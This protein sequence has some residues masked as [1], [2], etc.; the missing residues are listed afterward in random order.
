MAQTLGS[1]GYYAFMIDN[2]GKVVR[3]KATPE[4]VYD[5]KQQSNGLYSYAEGFS[6]WGY[7]GGDRSVHRLVDSSLA[8]VDSFKAGN[9]YDADSHEFRLLPNGH[10]LLHAYDIQY[11][12]LRATIPGASPN[13][14]VVGSILQELDLNKNVV[15]QWR[16]WDYIP[17]TDTYMSTT[18][19]AF[20]YIHVNAY[21]IDDD[22]NILACFR[23]TCE[24]VKINRMTGAI[25]WR[26]GGKR[27]E[28]TFIGENEANKPTYFT[29]Q[30]T[31]RKLPNGNLILFDNGNLH[32]PAQRYSRAVEY[33]VDQVAKTATL[34][35][36]YRH[37]PDIY[38]PQRGSVQR[39]ANGNTVIGW[40]N[41][42]L[43]GVGKAAFTEV[44]PSKAT[45]CEMEFVNQTSS[46]RALKYEIGAPFSGAATV[47]I[48]EVLRGNTYQ[49]KQGDAQTG[50]S[51]VFSQMAGTYNSVDSE[52]S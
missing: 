32:A 20:D 11:F 35:W 33:K 12:D 38:T 48:N 18:A 44:T 6:A 37:T 42:A 47:R 39:L 52:A 34:V 23:N 5:F 1:D 25:M 31:L 16:S 30:H 45:V 17:I 14:I 19:S 26:M 4:E 29:Y 40:G 51:M 36:E 21:D 9:G 46:Y 41:N 13:A 15:F 22:G 50:V 28:F 3:Y 2:A 27:N 8:P 7:A 10:A 24:I 49:F 43:T